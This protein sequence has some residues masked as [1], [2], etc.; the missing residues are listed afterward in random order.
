MSSAEFTKI[1]LQTG[2]GFVVLGFVGFFVK[3]LF[4]VRSSRLPC[5]RAVQLLRVLRAKTVVMSVQ[6]INQI[7]IGA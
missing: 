2:L 1:L 5:W 7:I 6:P 3:L 4:I